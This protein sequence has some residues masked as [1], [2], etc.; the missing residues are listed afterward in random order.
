MAGT[1]RVSEGDTEFINR[2]R[3][4]ADSVDKIGDRFTGLQH[5]AS[6]GLGDVYVGYD[7]SIGRLVALKLLKPHLVTSAEAQQRFLNECSVTGLLEH[8]AIVPVYDSG[9]TDEGRPYYAMRLL[10]GQTLQE[11]I[12]N[13]HAIRSDDFHKRQRSLI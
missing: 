9:V 13:L 1:E 3:E 10:D 11:E 6:G 12:S 4:V 5:I 8:P 2:G 7:E